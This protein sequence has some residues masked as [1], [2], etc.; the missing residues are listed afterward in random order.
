MYN[1]IRT[2]TNVTDFQRKDFEE[3]VEIGTKLSTLVNTGSKFPV[4]HY[5]N[6]ARMN[7]DKILYKRFY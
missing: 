4:S 3:Q 5:L 1:Y 2:K 7:K 6:V